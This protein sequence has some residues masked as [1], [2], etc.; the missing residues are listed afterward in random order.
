MTNLQKKEYLRVSKFFYKKIMKLGYESTDKGLHKSDKGY[1]LYRRCNESN[2]CKS[3]W[4]LDV[5]VPNG[6]CRINL[7]KKCQHIEIDR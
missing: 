7:N 1:K 5:H 2:D 6:N 4:I 3:T